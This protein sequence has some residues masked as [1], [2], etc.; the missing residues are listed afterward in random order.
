MAC[1][2]PETQALRPRIRV[3]RE[4]SS[5]CVTWTKGSGHKLKEMPNRA[6]ER[7]LGRPRDELKRDVRKLKAL[8]LTSILKIGYRLTP[9]GAA[10]LKH[11][12]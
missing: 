11:M 12:R 10:L 7:S 8:G 1:D 4:M 5:P 2:S 3:T 6:Y 9:K